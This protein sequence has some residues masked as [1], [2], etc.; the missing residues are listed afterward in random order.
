MR[1]QGNTAIVYELRRSCELQFANLQGEFSNAISNTQEYLGETRMHLERFL[2]AK[3]QKMASLQV[4]CGNVT[5]WQV[6]H[7]CRAHNLEHFMVSKAE[8]S[9]QP[10][11]GQNALCC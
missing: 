1:E 7:L 10:L 6:Q 4:S 2:T 11:S 3:D 9:R 5:F 8:Y